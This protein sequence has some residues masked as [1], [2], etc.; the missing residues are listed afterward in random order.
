[1]GRSGGYSL[2]ETAVAMTLVGLA[3]GAYLQHF[4][5]QHERARYET[6]QK[7]LEA[8]RTALTAYAA[9]K[10]HLPC[11]Q[12]PETAISP[13]FRKSRFSSRKEDEAGTSC[14]PDALPPKGVVVFTSNKPSPGKTMEEVW[15]GA[16]P[17]RDLRLNDEQT[18]D[19][20]GRLFTY[21]V[22]SSLTLPDSLRKNPLP[23]G[24]ITVEDAFGNSLLPT[25]NT[26][27]YAVVSHGPTGAGGWA[28]EGGRKPCGTKKTLDSKNCDDDA[29]FVSAPYAPSGGKKFF[30][31]L[32]IFD[33]L[34]A[35]GTLLDKLVKCNAKK[36]FYLPGEDGADEDGC[37]GYKNVIEGACLIRMTLMPSGEFKRDAPAALMPPSVPQGSECGCAPGYTTIELGGWDVKNPTASDTKVEGGGETA[38]DQENAYVRSA[39]YVC[40]R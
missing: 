15:T 40:T 17:A 7:R 19:G 21:A 4:T 22:S 11:P 31:D 24:I 6:T 12:S 8:V 26:G 3:L 30:D 32:I 13:T 20:W 5:A 29:A 28:K 10:G 2:V 39:L 27:R 25:P 18:Y 16:L 36:Q 34:D 33:D 37:K 1:M 14:G 9:Q 23:P 35:G 38:G